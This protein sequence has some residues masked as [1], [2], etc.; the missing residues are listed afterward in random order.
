MALPT[1]ARIPPLVDHELTDEQAEV[2]ERFRTPNGIFNIFRT[3][4]HSPKALKGFGAWGNYVLSD[5]NTIPADRRELVILRTGLL[6]GSIY[7]WAQHVLIGGFLGLTAEEIERV[8]VGPDDAAW[9]PSDRAL[10]RAVDELHSAQQIS[11]ETWHALENDAGLDDRQKM[12]LVFTIGHYTMVAMMLNSF[13]VQLDDG[14]EPDPSG[15][16]PAS[17]RPPVSTASRRRSEGDRD[18]QGN[19]HD[20]HGVGDRA[21]ARSVR[22]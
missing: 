11:D 3:L 15:S 18:E 7:E 10:L 20:C 2:L 13:G 14:L 19:Q 1:E 12:D 5:R 22:K 4:A 16:R 8:K 17:S 6:C 9:S 21:H